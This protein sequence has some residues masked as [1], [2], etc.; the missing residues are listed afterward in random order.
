MAN[1]LFGKIA[2][3][4]VP[5]LSSVFSGRNLAVAFVFVLVGLICFRNYNL[6]S[7]LW[8]WRPR[9]IRFPH[10][11]GGRLLWVGIAFTPR[12]L[13]LVLNR[14]FC[15]STDNSRTSSAPDSVEN[16]PEMLDNATS[17]RVPNA[18]LGETELK[19]LMSHIMES[20]GGPPWQLMME[21]P[22]PT[23][24]YK[25]WCRDPQVG[26]TQYRTRTVFMD[27]SPELLRD[28]FWD[29]EFRLKWDK[30][31]VYC[32]TLHVCPRTG[33]MVVHWIRKLPL[34]RTE[35]EYVIIRRIWQSESSYYCVTKGITYPSLPNRRNT[36]RVELYYSSWCINPVESGNRQQ[37][38]ASEVIFFHY[39][40]IGVPKEIVKMCARAGMWGLVKKMAAAAQA[41]NLARASS[42]PRSSYAVLACITTECGPLTFPAPNVEVHKDEKLKDTRRKD[43]NPWKWL[44]VGGVLIASGLTLQVTGKV[45]LFQ[46][47]RWMTRFARA[48]GNQRKH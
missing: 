48:K 2:L 34:I 37:H 41:Y 45:V 5:A 21:R 19:E 36:R 11:F 12:Q 32:R 24:T 47:G 8:M 38:P 15:H 3:E 35:R 4:D 22:T 42:A 23:L 33:T 46:L 43:V 6:C 18:A 29:D 10:V 20:D 17:D 30:M 25:A 39:E 44:V 7:Y 9:R 16:H 13:C 27:I 1:D 14:I 40:D 28:F 31:L 26:P